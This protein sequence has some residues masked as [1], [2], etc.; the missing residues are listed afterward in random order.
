M[1]N[2]IF[3]AFLIFVL[4]F[5]SLFL[6][7]KLIGPI[8]FSVI[9]TN[10]NK[11]D[12]FSVSG[13]GK[14]IVK[15]DIAY[16]SVGVEATGAT[17][18]QTQDKINSAIN[19]VI[20]SVKK[21]GIDEKDI[22]TTNYSIHPT[23]DWTSGRQRII[24]FTANTNLSVKIRNIDKVNEVIDQ[25]T[26][27]GANQI[28]GISFDVDDKTKA[29]DQA[30]KDAVAEAKKKAKQASEIAG[31]KLGKIINYSESTN[32]YPRPLNYGG[33]LMLEKAAAPATDIQTGSSEIKITVSL[34]YQIE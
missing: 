26:A 17:V 28:G 25:A 20:A 33:G 19:N 3:S 29:E 10:T 23:Y 31:F 9:S 27:S 14:V 4:F 5:L 34:S 22:K 6:Y 7:T 16:V 12:V 11:T 13:E 18:K 15:P 32:D 30:R 24:G 1:Q 21:L 8:P 2:K